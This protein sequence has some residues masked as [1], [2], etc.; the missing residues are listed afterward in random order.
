MVVRVDNGFKFILILSV[1]VFLLY[2]F[3][4]VDFGGEVEDRGG[5]CSG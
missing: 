5:R 1:G 4:N 3:F 2:S